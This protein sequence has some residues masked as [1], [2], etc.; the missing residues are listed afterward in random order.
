LLSSI[1]PL[2]RKAIKFSH[3]AGVLA[4]YGLRSPPVGV[5]KRGTV[6]RFLQQTQPAP[7]HLDVAFQPKP[8]FQGLHEL[9]YTIDKQSF[10]HVPEGVAAFERTPG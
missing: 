1:E 7:N 3:V 8:T 6:R 5:P 4:A 9:I 2:V 10:H